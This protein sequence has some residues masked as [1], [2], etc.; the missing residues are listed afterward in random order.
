MG[1]SVSSMDIFVLY[2]L[3]DDFV[4]ISLV[5]FVLASVICI[6]FLGA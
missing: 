2:S 4:C 1:K 6:V 3:R 5:A